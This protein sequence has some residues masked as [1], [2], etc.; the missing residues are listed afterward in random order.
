MKGLV[1]LTMALLVG[2]VEFKTLEELEFAALES[3]DWSA[4]HQRE[5]KIAKREAQKAARCP[6]GHIRVCRNRVRDEQCYCASEE[7]V[8]EILRGF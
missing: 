4:V 1:V 6:S 8:S 7:H 5:R 3:G 2:C